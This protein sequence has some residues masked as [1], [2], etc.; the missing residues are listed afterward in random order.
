MQ[1]WPAPHPHCPGPTQGQVSLLW[2]N[3]GSEREGA[4]AELATS[5]LRRRRARGCYPTPSM[6]WKWEPRMDLPCRVSSQ[7]QNCPE[8]EKGPPWKVGVPHTEPTVPTLN[9]AQLPG[10]ARPAH[11]SP[12]LW[13]PTRRCRGPM[14]PVRLSPGLTTCESRDIMERNKIFELEGKET[15]CME[16]QDGGE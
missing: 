3:E 6:V 1:G 11:Q 5:T 12:G 4:E 8:P 9:P 10:Q 14:E 7:T 2:R 16:P 15:V 13:G